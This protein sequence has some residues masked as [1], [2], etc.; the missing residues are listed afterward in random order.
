MKTMN[1]L[2]VLN[3][4][5]IALGLAVAAL[6]AILLGGVVAELLDRRRRRHAQEHRPAL[7]LVPPPRRVA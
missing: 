5:N 7:R 2:T 3:A 6:W 1:D 4:T